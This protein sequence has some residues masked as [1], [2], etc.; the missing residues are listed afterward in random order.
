MNFVTNWVAIELPFFIWQSSKLYVR[1]C[2]KGKQNK[3]ILVESGKNRLLA[4]ISPQD[5]K[6]WDHWSVPLI[7]ARVVQG[8]LSSQNLGNL[9][10]TTSCQWPPW[11]HARVGQN[12]I[13]SNSLTRS[14]SVS[15]RPSKT[16]K[17]STW[18]PK[19]SWPWVR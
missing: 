4:W 5:P 13:Q 6:I 1:R 10:P 7:K 11:R 12:R 3:F 17:S 8:S 15:K 19:T 9:L 14:S 16:W 18:T 2:E